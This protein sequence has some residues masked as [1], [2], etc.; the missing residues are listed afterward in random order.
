MIDAR[1]VLALVVR[2]RLW[3]TAARELVRFAPRGWWRR[4][5][6]LPRPDPD[7]AAFRVH[8]ALGSDP[9]AHLETAEVVAFLDWCR[10]TE[11]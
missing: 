6:P 2:P 3:L 9:S 7:Y 5:P 11:P 1:L 4:W 10:Q 8:T